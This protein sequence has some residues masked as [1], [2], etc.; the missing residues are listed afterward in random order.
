MRTKELKAIWLVYTNPAQSMPNLNTVHDGLSNAEFVVV[1]EAYA[2]TATTL[3]ADILLPATTLAEKIGTVTNSERRI[4]QVNPAIKLYASSKHD[5]QIALEVARA[6]EELLRDNKMNG[7]STLCSDCGPEDIWNE[8]RESTSGRD[9]DNTSLS[10][11]ILEEG[12]PQQWS[13]P[14]RNCFGKKRLYKN[15]VFP[16]KDK[17]LTLLQHHIRQL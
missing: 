11:Q 13:M 14:N 8:H 5:W 7:V 12:G 3:Y 9:L 15:G 4:S 1:Q 2:H 16:T 10:Y 6:L 17:R